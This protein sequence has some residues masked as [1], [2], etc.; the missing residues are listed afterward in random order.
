LGTPLRSFLPGLH[1]DGA[2]PDEDEVTPLLWIDRRDH[3]D[4]TLDRRGGVETQTLAVAGTDHLDHPRRLRGAPR[5]AA[6]RVDGWDHAH[7]ADGPGRG[8]ADPERN[9]RADGGGELGVGFLAIVPCPQQRLR[10]QLDRWR[11]DLVDGVAGIEQ[12]CGRLPLG[13]RRHGFQAERRG[14][15][16]CARR[17]T[18]VVRVRAGAA[19]STYRVH[20]AGRGMPLTIYSRSV[21]QLCNLQVLSCC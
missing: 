21:S 3:A 4:P 2:G 17:C 8:G 10:G 9:I 20:S 15:E 11:L 12:R 7:A 16:V 6:R 19:A 14:T 13:D 5:W 18:P 1:P